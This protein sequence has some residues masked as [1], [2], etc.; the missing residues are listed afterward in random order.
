MVRKYGRWE[1]TRLDGSFFGDFLFPLFI[2]SKK[3]RS[4]FGPSR[5]AADG[6]SIGLA[7]LNENSSCKLT[8][9]PEP[10]SSGP[11]APFLGGWPIHRFYFACAITTLG[12]PTRR[13]P[14]KIENPTV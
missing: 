13:D 1:K 8:T 4:L 5:M 11:G 2:L 14:I 9:W 6:L 7:G 10:K 3:A 12:C